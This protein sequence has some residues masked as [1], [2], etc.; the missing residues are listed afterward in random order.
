LV[1]VVQEHLLFLLVQMERTQEFLLQVVVRYWVVFLGQLAAAVA[2][3]GLAIVQV[4][5]VVP[6]VVDSKVEQVVLEHQDKVM[7]V[8]HNHHLQQVLLVLVVAVV[9][10][11]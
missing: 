9:Q 8:E 5:P 6:V 7:L 10:E 1:V 4:F 11:V 3:V 2:L